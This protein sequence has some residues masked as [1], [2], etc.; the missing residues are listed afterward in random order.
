MKTLTACTW[1]V[2]IIAAVAGASFTNIRF[3]ARI[4]GMAES[5]DAGAAAPEAAGTAWED[6]RRVREREAMRGILYDTGFAEVDAATAGG[7]AARGTIGQALV[8]FDRGMEYLES[9]TFTSAIGAFTKAVIIAPDHAPLY[10]G[11]GRA[12]V[13][14]RKEKEGAAAYRTAIRLDPRSASAHFGLADALQRLGE[15]EQAAAEYRAALDID[16][17]HAQARLRLACVS[18]LLGDRG[19]AA[20][21]ARA[22]QALGERLPVA[23]AALIEGRE[24]A[25]AVVRGAAAPAIGPQIRID[26]G[27]LKAANETTIS[28]TDLFPMEIVAGWNDYRQDGVIRNAV[29]VSM[30]GGATWTDF[31]LRPPPANQ[32]TVEGDPMTAYD[33]R[34]GTLWAGGISFA[35]NGGL[36]VARKDPGSPTFGPVVMAKQAAGVDKGWMAAG[37]DPNFGTLTRVYIAYNHGVVRSAD[38]GD[39]WAGPVSLGSGL[40]FLPRVGPLGQ[41]YVEYWDGGDGVMLRTSLTGGVSFGAP[42]EAATRLD[43]WG[44][45]GTRF[46]G[47]FRVPPI[48]TMAVDANTGRLYIVYFDTTNIVNGSRNVDLYFTKSSNGGATWTE[49]AIINGDSV[50]PGDSFFPWIEV[51]ASGRLHM[52]FLDTRNAPG[53]DSDPIAWIDAYY[54][55][56]DD[57]GES[58]TETRLTP[59]S[60]NSELDGRNAATSFIGD[61]MGLAVGGERIY[62]CYVSNQNLSSDIFIHQISWATPSC[63]GDLDGDGDTDSTDL[64]LVLTSF[65]CSGG[66]CAGDADG[67]G[68]TDSVDLNVVLTDM[69]CDA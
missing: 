51:D 66:G 33:P 4:A 46:P 48:N 9:N 14:K 65:G 41:L 20:E 8:E 29:A 26:T 68:D 16:A 15:Y 44:V 13:L 40:G 34:T 62:P 58:W 38:M 27:G 22:A 19:A 69:G 53:N 55:Y 47:T 36:F 7:V 23:L 5:A 49:P 50:P 25:R 57:E 32:A 56:S 39:T 64:N 42:V 21:H 52:V 1:S 17:N 37:R 60:F 63:T 61:Y 59:S 18:F 30:D 12:L 10:E 28:S 24:P 3:A 6:P 11:L 43:V 31:M 35:S 2:A 67:D 45:D 54:S